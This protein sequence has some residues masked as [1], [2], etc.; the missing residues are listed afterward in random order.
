M[1]DLKTNIYYLK[2]NIES[3]LE[4]IVAIFPPIWSRRSQRT[5]QVEFCYWNH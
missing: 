4:T 1:T 5:K 2:M 3:L